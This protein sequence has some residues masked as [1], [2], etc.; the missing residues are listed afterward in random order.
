MKTV[1][2]FNRYALSLAVSCALGTAALAQPDSGS[3]LRDTQ[4]PKVEKEKAPLPD[5]KTPEYKTPMAPDSDAKVEVKD[6]SISGNTVFT[7]EKLLKLLDKY[8][9]QKL[10]IDELY[11]A[12]R[13]ITR[14]YRD[15]GYFVARAYIPNQEIDK[16]KSTVEITVIEGRY[17]SF[18][19]DNSSNVDTEVT[20]GYMD[21]LTGGD[22]V[23]TQ[24]LERQMLIINDL[25]GAKVTDAQI[26]P[27]K[28]VGT[29]DFIIEVSPQD[30][31]SGYA[32]IDN[33]GSRYTGIHRLNVGA[34]VN[35]ATGV[36]DTL[37]FT[38][39]LSQT[40]DLANARVAY[41]RYIGYSGLKAGFSAAYTE[42]ELG[43]EFKDL[44]A[45]GDTTQLSANLSYPLVKTRAHTL[46]VK[47]SYDHKELN[48]QT[49]NSD[50]KKQTDSLTAALSDSFNTAW[51]NRFG[52]LSSTVS[53][54]A[55]ELELK[56]DDAKANDA[57]IDS[58]GGYSKLN[59]EIT[60]MQTLSR[61]LYLTATFKGQ[62]SLGENMDSSESF[63]AGGAY[64]V[65]AYKDSELSGDRGYLASLE[66]SYKLPN[67]KGI[68]QTLSTFVDHAKVWTYHD[69]P[70][71]INE[72]S[73]I[74]NGAGIGYS[75]GYKDFSVQTTFARGFGGDRE[76]QA[77]GG[78]A[79]N[80]L[81]LVQGLW[82][83]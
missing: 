77:D 73:R 64:G 38:G 27:G 6:F 10:S 66:L 30:K 20:Q 44:E 67:Y 39:L 82:R 12:A 60:Q 3:V 71:G 47:L 40:G 22:I 14:Y 21:M 61:S 11:E 32:M 46:D 36:G 62:Q 31:Y 43:K 15:H 55:G 18:K 59:A 57:D 1:N 56:T 58:R 17:G 68:T 75:A 63:S 26:M 41:D 16:D 49:V 53:V 78:N 54:T 9:G 48:D 34:F 19:M 23:S 80:N 7:D 5:L 42:Y 4:P 52:K 79:D 24:S 74:L 72:N 25:G 8:R 45:K 35:S 50:S 13:V 29:S 70:A 33:Y 76:V 51:F 83:F 2:R 65:R 28:E 69:K 81:L 37:S